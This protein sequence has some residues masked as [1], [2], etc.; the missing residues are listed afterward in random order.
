MV[1]SERADR[2]TQGH[3][4][5][6]EPSSQPP[7]GDLQSEQEISLDASGLSAQETAC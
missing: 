4:E 5:E 3:E 1:A 7:S 6:T 2:F